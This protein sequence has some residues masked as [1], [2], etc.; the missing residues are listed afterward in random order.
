[1]VRDV[2]ELFGRIDVLVCNAGI[3][4]QRLF[5][6]ITEE[7]WNRM[8]GVHLSGTFHCCHAVLPQMIHRKEEI[9]RAHV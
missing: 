1:M 4:Q 6:D 5:Q 7:E 2:T 9:G 8:I 3:A